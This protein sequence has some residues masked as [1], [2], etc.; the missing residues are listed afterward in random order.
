MKL[1]LKSI[2]ITS[3]AL[4]AVIAVIPAAGG[5][6]HAEESASRTEAGAARPEVSQERVDA[7]IKAGL[8]WLAANQ[9]KDGPDAGRWE[10]PRYHVAASG[11]AGLS[12]LAN[13]HLPSDETYGET[14]SNA[15]SYIR[16]CMDADGYV[17]GR[18]GTMYVHS[19]AGLFVLSYVGMSGDSDYD[20][21]LAEWLRRALELSVKA[22]QVRKA[23]TSDRG[24]W[25]YFPHS[26]D[27]DV[28]HTTW[29]L[30]LLYAARQAGFAVPEQVFEDAIR[31]VNSCF[32]E[33]DDR[34]AGFLYRLG[35][36]QEQG[37][38]TS[39]AALMIKRLVERRWDER[40]QKTLET[41]Q[42]FRPVWDGKPYKGYFYYGN[43]YIAQGIF[44]SSQDLW[45]DYA[46]R[47]KEVL[48]E[49]QSGDG[50]WEFPPNATVQ[51]QY[52]GK[53]YATGMAILLLSLDKQFLPVFQRVDDASH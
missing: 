6:A 12:F 52:A 47:L 25:R 22:Q 15:L 11:I 43:F 35:T 1:S 50:S 45:K 27:S 10:A 30:L 9:I 36:T 33:P 34:R 2:V 40:S 3:I 44:H 17:G 48:V 8:D 18:H 42:K 32:I 28:S 14:V 20:I 49:N 39:G 4:I 31:Y 26:V 53:A 37:E 5:A 46:P 13:G 38:G 24:G 21:E 23:L 7:A 16:G 51:P 41:L 19:I 29:Q